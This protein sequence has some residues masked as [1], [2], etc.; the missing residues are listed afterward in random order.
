[1]ETE[2]MLWPDLP[3]DGFSE[4]YRPSNSGE[5]MYFE[6]QWCWNCAKYDDGACDILCAVYCHS[7]DEVGYPSEW[8]IIN[9]RPK[10]TAF[11]EMPRDD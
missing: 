8:A 9:D 5:G 10:C 6:S 4:P 7:I 1:M 11:V 3:Y 2:P